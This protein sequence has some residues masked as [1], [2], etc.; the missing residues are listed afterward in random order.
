MMCHKDSYVS[1]LERA[2]Q[3]EIQKKKTEE[4]LTN[5]TQT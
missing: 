2:K 4:K 5:L 1:G 3:V